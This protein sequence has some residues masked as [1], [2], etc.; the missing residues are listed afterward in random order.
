VTVRAEEIA[1]GEED[2]MHRL[3]VIVAAASV[4]AGVVPAA[5]TDPGPTRS[6]DARF[7]LHVVRLIAANRYSDAWRTLHPRHQLAA[8]R[9]IYVRCEQQTSIPGTLRSA[10]VLD[11]ADATIHVAGV[12]RPVV[13]GAVQIRIVIAGRPV[14]EGV[15]VDLKVHVV[16]VHGRRAWILPPERF[17]A[18]AEGICP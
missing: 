17:A 14:P 7:A 4:A 13:A 1:G 11:V 15:S 5:A 18:Y 2:A 9:A 6:G 10:R 3:V 12:T 16:R 8:P